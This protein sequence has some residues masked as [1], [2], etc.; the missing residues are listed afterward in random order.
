MVNELVNNFGTIILIT[1]VFG[2]GIVTLLSGYVK[3]SPDTAY[4]IS[5]LR[6]NLK[7]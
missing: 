1:V 7:F 2:I 3:A 4:I 5:G 6:K